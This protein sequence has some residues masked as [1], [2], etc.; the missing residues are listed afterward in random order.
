MEWMKRKTSWEKEW[1]LL[2]K[3]ETGFL[4]K[5]EVESPSLI[6][7]KLKEVIPDS[8]QEKL[9]MAFEKA[10]QIVFEKGTGFIEKTYKK[11]RGEE[12]Y[13]VHEFT[14]GLRQNRKNIK[15]FSKQAEKTNR[16]NLLVSGVEGVGLGL[17]GVGIP[18]I[19]LFTAMILKSVY[20]IA[21]SYGYVY[22]TPEERL[23]ILKVIRTALEHGEELHALNCELD[24]MIEGKILWTGEQ[25]K[26]IK[27]TAETLSKELLYMKF[28][29]GMPI[30]GVVGGIADTIYLKKI[31]DYAVLKYQKRF[32]IKIKKN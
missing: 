5:Q 29:Q 12:A 8:L 18:D 19:P 25:R 7:R 22:D 16:K 15:A 14:V 30:V 28:L 20:E 3:R 27:K 2:N 21:I 23:F 26:E 11:E 4:K 9:D 24:N 1:E 6:N 13:K 17:L 31:T 10:F 32:L